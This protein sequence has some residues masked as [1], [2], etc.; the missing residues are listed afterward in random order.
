MAAVLEINISHQ[1][2][3]QTA[4]SNASIGPLNLN[5]HNLNLLDVRWRTASHRFENS[6]IDVSQQR[7]DH[8]RKIK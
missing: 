3:D 2:L 6:L 8:R 4:H 7:L 5:G 1:R